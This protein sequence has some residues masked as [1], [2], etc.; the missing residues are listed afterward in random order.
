MA[1]GIRRVITRNKE[2]M[3]V[4]TL[5]DMQGTV[6]VV[7]FPRTYA[8]AGVAAKLTDDG[9][10]LIA[11]R[12]DHKGDETVVLA[13]TVWTWDEVTE[14][15]QAQFAAEVAAGDRGR[16]GGRRRNGNGSS[17]GQGRGAPT[18]NGAPG[19]SPSGTVPVEAAS[20]SPV[21][22]MVV[23]QVSPLR[24]SEP[25]GTITISIGGAS[26]RRPTSPPG[27][28]MPPP[29]D[30]MPP[31]D[32]PPQEPVEPISGPSQPPAFEGL[33]PDGGDEPPLPDEASA[34]VAEAARARTAQVE[35]GPDQV[36]HI[37]F[38]PAPD[39][40]IVA[41]FEQLKALIKSRPGSTPVVLHIPAGPRRSQEM[42]LGVGIAY[43][44][45]LLAEVVRRFGALLQ[46][47][48]V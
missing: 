36:L 26:G 20:S 14:K 28:T 43:D 33:A 40:R 19:P 39:E 13:D 31:L 11:G 16:R 2:S 6:D 12:V 15:G 4:V 3:A 24:G 18:D 45:E 37:S 22:T 27:D 23:P 32:I 5:E 21:E 29:M 47:R 34:A 48:L 46:L 38:A 9:V 25:Q 1:V 42:R 44:A 10:L 17:N 41:A 30:A 7:V 35:A 8:D